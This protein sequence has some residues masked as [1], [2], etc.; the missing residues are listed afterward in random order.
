MIEFK[1]KIADR[2]VAYHAEIRDIL[3]EYLVEHKEID[4]ATIGD[5]GFVILSL[6]LILLVLLV[7]LVLLIFV[8]VVLRLVLLILVLIIHYEFLRNIVCG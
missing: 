7:L 4:P 2:V 3:Y 8:L 5:R 1:I 6:V